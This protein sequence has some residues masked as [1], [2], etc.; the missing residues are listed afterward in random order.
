MT[1]LLKYLYQNHVLANLLFA[2]VLVMG[3]MS[4]IS[5]PREQ[6]PSINFNWIQV[7][8]ILPG[9]TA[10]DVEK[11]ITDPL[12]EAI[13]KLS[14]TRFVSSNS[15]ESV[16]SILVRFDDLDSKTFDKR[17]N[18][19][20]RDIQN[21]SDELPEEAKQTN[22]LEITSANAFPSAI[23]VV[24]GQANDERLR[25][26]TKWIKEDIERLAGV[27]RVEAFGLHAPELQVLFN[28][29][30]LVNH[31][32]NALDLG[33]SIK[34][35]FQDVSLGTLDVGTQKWL[36]RWMG[37]QEA[38]EY[39]SRLPILSAKEELL[40]GEV[41]TVQRAREKEVRLVNYEGKNA[42]MLSVMKKGGTNTLKL[43][44]KLKTYIADKNLKSQATGI[45]VV[46]LD[47]Q[48]EV[49]RSALNIMQTN[50]LFGLILVLFTTW[51]FLGLRMAIIISIGIPFILAATFWILNLLDQTLNVSVLLATVITLGMLVDDSVVVIEAIYFRLSHN[52]PKL[53]AI[54]ESLQ[55]VSGP[56]T[57]SVLTTS[58]AFV[59]LMLLPGILG[60]FMMVIPMVVTIALIIS[61]I[62][63]YWMLP[64][65]IQAFPINLKQTS[66]QIMRNRLN[67]K[68]KILY[69]KLLI[70]VF[71][72][73]KL[74]CFFI[75][76]LLGL[77]LFPVIKGYIHINFF[78]SDPLRIFY[79]NVE[80]PAGTTLKSTLAQ[81]RILEEKVRKHLHTSE[82]RS[83]AAYAGL[84]F[85]ETAPFLGD[86][87]GQIV[88]SLNPQSNNSRHV[89]TIIDAMRN[90]I[91]NTAGPLNISFLRLSG[92][93]PTSKPINIK[94]RGSQYSQIRA[95][96]QKLKDKLKSLDYIYDISDDDSLGSKELTLRPNLDAIYR[97][98]LNPAQ[99]SRLIRLFM[100]GEIVTDFQSDGEKINVRVKAMYKNY[101]GISEILHQTIVIAGKEIRLSE[102]VYADTQ[103]SINN[104]RHYNFRRAITV[105]AEIDK[106]VTDT[107]AVNKIIQSYWQD[108]ANNYPD[109]DLNFSGELDDIQESLDAIPMLFLFGVGII[110]LILGT[111]FRSYWQP[112]MILATIPLAFSGVVFGLLITG[113]PL[114]L[115][116]M[117][118]IVALSGI[119]VNASIVL[120][121]AANQRL[122]NGMSLEHATLYAARRRLIPILITSLTTIAGLFSLATGL[123]GKSLLWGPVATSIVW[124]LMFS[125][126]LTLF[127]IP[128]LYRLCSTK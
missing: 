45:D 85:S 93:P 108:I 8:T 23:L 24:V 87:Y 21:K 7:T 96:V 63:A 124:G 11:L 17:V 2:L 109:I 74:A 57:T 4:Y 79:V 103:P 105:T 64:A 18:E 56:V 67:H 39:M 121:S 113:N 12:E 36:A 89:D 83:I 52:M 122:E 66:I 48:T 125:T 101:S 88:I 35:H 92:G 46:L 107:I 116:T 41:A 78:A 71:R 123:G 127:F 60:K 99:V 128:L 76:C 111:Q 72:R 40:L 28:N 98:N 115:F 82:I 33:A 54:I 3:F 6:D 75:I 69:M 53:Q 91:L 90:D 13:H 22:I 73:P 59:P 15:K 119:T 50:A 97:A 84:M 68:L 95:A 80:M 5:M 77:A 58:A 49:T 25:K 62:E 34:S 110:Y 102:L 16:S 112:F 38:P 86:K 106:E 14:D 42:I 30:T 26:Q 51:I 118:G 55:E 19:L 117:Y 61:L 94:V 20:R 9:A 120:I 1:K 100:D 104:I 32:I 27:D 47:D 10:S 31:Q 44:K 70:K 81:T 114:S 65:H 37:I 126:I 43:I 29:N